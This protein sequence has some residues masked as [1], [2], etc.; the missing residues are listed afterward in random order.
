MPKKS[1]GEQIALAAS[2]VDGHIHMVRSHRVMVS[3]E[4]AALYQ[5]EPKVLVQAVKRKASRFPA[6]FLFQ[7]TS[8]EFE[9]L[10]SQS[11]TS[12]HG[13]IRRALPY[14]FTEQGVAMLSSV[15]NSPRSIQVNIGIMRAFV[16]MREAALA[17][18]ELLVQLN[19]MEKK[20]DAQFQV[21]FTAIKKLMEPSP[22][23]PAKRIGFRAS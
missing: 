8:E 10:K 19:A 15:L 21:V 13:G 23:P 18:K 22:A 7:L 11:V 14:A 20:Y 5:V 4:L 3:T 1:K 2:A 9:N 16:K 6:D 17:H 12:S